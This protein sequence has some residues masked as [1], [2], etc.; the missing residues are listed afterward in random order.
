MNLDGIDLV[1]WDVDGTLY[2][3][4]TLA[5]WTRLVFLMRWRELGWTAAREEALRAKR[6]R[7]RVHRQRQGEA[8]VEWDPEYAGDAE[9]L[10]VYVC[11]GLRWIKPAPGAIALMDRIAAAGIT[12][13]AISDFAAPQKL[14]AMGIRHRFAAAYSCEELGHW[15]PSPLPFQHVQRTHQISPEHHLHIGDREDLDGRAATAAGGRF[16]LH[17]A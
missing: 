8:K 6:H 13:V 15:K 17:R 5:R 2:P 11:G 7:R 4:R 10:S 9:A 14:D 1:S 3:V 16:L 12:Q